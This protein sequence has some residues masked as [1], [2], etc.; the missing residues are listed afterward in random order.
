M[1]EKSGGEGK[2]V[3]AG[4]GRE[5]TQGYET[6]RRS[7]ISLRR[8]LKK[9]NYNVLGQ[10][11]NS[12]IPN[13]I[14]KGSYVVAKK[15][16]EGLIVLATSELFREKFHY[17][18]K[19]HGEPFNE[20]IRSPEDIVRPGSLANIVEAG[21]ERELSVPIYDGAEKEILTYITINKPSI[22]S[23]PL[24]FLGTRKEDEYIYTQIEIIGVGEVVRKEGEFSK[25][26]YRTLRSPVDEYE[27]RIKR[28]VGVLRKVRGGE[29]R[30]AIWNVEIGLKRR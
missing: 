26:R 23:V 13:L 4:V 21:K 18:E 29:S 11:E 12:L 24:R 19:I 28:C 1:S 14:G 8:M 20:V 16:E 17:A 6:I 7:H 5:W 25:R 15:S 30:K 9:G 2:G 27:D 10:A 22:L 3:I